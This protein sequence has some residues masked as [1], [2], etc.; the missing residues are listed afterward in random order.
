MIVTRFAAEIE[1]LRAF[2]DRS[3]QTGDHRD[4]LVAARVGAPAHTD[5][6]APT[7]DADPV[8]EADDPVERVADEQ[9]GPAAV[10]RREKR[11]QTPCGV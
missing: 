5:L 10:A 6:L 9:D 11:P 4:D 1:P 7:Q 2:A 3:P 8:G